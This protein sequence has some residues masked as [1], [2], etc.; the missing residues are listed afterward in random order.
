[1]GAAMS[2]R[3]IP[4]SAVTFFVR[5]T[6][7]NTKAF[8]E[9]NKDEYNTIVK[10]SFE[11]LLAGLGSDFGPWRIYRP[12]RDTRFAID[13]SPYKTFVGAVTQQSGGTGYFVQI[14]AK[15]LLVG[16]GYP[17]MTPDQL[18]RFRAAIDSDHGDEFVRLVDTQRKL[19]V[20]VTGGRYDVLKRVPRGYPSDHPR[21]EWLRV[22]GIELP[23]RAGTPK[24]F[25]TNAAPTKTLELLQRGRPINE[26]LDTHVG[27]S[28]MTPEEI[29]G[30]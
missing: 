30:R 5:L 1:M 7:D 29:W 14:S 26:W 22:K 28:T 8:W 25:N 18:E 2:T 19:G 16:S 9:A 11:N 21:S 10:P 3:G 15:G 17:M 20:E 27:P 24:W 12:H 23:N 6:N 13:K 4:L